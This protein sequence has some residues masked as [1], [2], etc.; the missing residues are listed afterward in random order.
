MTNDSVASVTAAHPPGVSVTAV[1][2]STAAEAPPSASLRS[3]VEQTL[4]PGCYEIVVVHDS[5]D[6]ATATYVRELRSKHPDHLLRLVGVADL[7]LISRAASHLLGIGAARGEHVAVVDADHEAGPG[8]LEALLAAAAPGRVP[9]ILGPATAARLAQHIGSTIDPA[10]APDAL[11]TVTG[12]LLPTTPT[13]VGAGARQSAVESDALL[14]AEL[15]ARF[16]FRLRLLPGSP[17]TELRQLDPA[18]DAAHHERETLPETLAEVAALGRLVSTAPAASG[19]A[20]VLAERHADVVSRQLASA[21]IDRADLVARAVRQGA[22]YRPFWQA[23]NDGTAEDLAFLYLFPPYQ[24]TSALVAGRRL[25]AR[26]VVTD[27]ISQQTDSLHAVDPSGVRVATEYVGRHQLL[28]GQAAVNRWAAARQYAEGAVRV[29]E[30]WQRQQGRPYRTVY[31]RAMAPASH[32]AA[33]LMKLRHPEI[34][35]TAEFSDPLHRNPYGECRVGEIGDDELRA[36]LVAGVQDA[37]FALPRSSLFFQWAELVP[38][39][40]ADEIVYTNDNQRRFMLDDVEDRALAQR[41]AERSTV[42]PHPTLP[43]EFYRLG[44]P[45][46]DLSPDT[47]NIAYFGAFYRTRGIVDVIAALA[48]LDAEERR[49]VRLHVFCA[50]PWQLRLQSL[51]LGIADMVAEHRYLPFL[52]FLAATT[53]FDALIVNDA[54]TAEHHGLNPYLPSKLSDY[55]G[56]GRPI[57]AV[58][59]PG[60]VLSTLPVDYRSEVGDAAGSL[61]ALRSI[62]A[63]GRRD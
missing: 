14:L 52:D 46:L 32:Y 13:R 43:A 30:D 51:E 31:S 59:E 42:S 11:S 45:H 35:W 56:S 34:R 53:R 25:R 47:V 36:T 10:E 41:A 55:R 61:Q 18:G 50:N 1:L 15:H 44:D 27:V 57:W 33:A 48:E 37:G 26:G 12:M 22:S 20:V 62:I 63:A 7:K 40:L 5:S 6:T 29:A 21:A 4:A 16:P 49:R 17:E 54:S 28:A 24:D 39:A 9:T 58:V 23:L 8:F 2:V 19:L 60:S 38:Y 3:L